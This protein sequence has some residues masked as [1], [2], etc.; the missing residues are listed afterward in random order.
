MGNLFG[1]EKI[2]NKLRKPF[3]KEGLQNLRK[4]RPYDW[5]YHLLILNQGNGAIQ[6][7]ILVE[8]LLGE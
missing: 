2:F 4:H 5:M 7:A 3:R 6:Y 1:K 8:E